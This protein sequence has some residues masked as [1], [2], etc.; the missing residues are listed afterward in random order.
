MKTHYSILLIFIAGLLLCSCAS[1]RLNVNGVVYHSIR[2]TDTIEEIPSDVKIIVSCD[3]SMKGIIEVEVVNNTGNVLLIDRTKSF[4]RD[5]DNYSHPFYDPTVNVNTTSYTNGNIVGGNINVG[6]VAKAAGVGGALGTALNAVTVGGAQSSSS[7]TSQTTYQI[8]QPVLSIAPHGKASMGRTFYEQYY[9]AELLHS[10]IT[11][12]EDNLVSYIYTPESS[13][14]A[15]HVSISYSLDNG[16]TYDIIEV[17][18][19]TQ[20]LIISKVAQVG[21]VNDALRRVYEAKNDLLDE[22]WYAI[23]FPYNNFD[24][25]STFGTDGERTYAYKAVRNKFVNYK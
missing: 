14:S 15:C 10:M 21:H 9:D 7:T 16:V 20:S 22:S 24:M 1:A 12:F 13:F 4:F 17:G 5:K 25:L 18:M 23:I 3:V 6:G 8:D 11:Y 2:N 19:Y